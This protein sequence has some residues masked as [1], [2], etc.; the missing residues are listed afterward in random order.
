MADTTNRMITES[1]YAT[2]I[3]EAGWIAASGDVDFTVATPPINW[4]SDNKRGFIIISPD[5]LAK[6]ERMFYH[7]VIGS[8]IYV[9]GINRTDAKA[10]LVSE[11]VQINDSSDLFNYF[12]DISSNTFYIIKTGGLNITVLGWPTMLVGTETKTAADTNITLSDD[13][14]NYIYYIPSTNLVASTTTFSAIAWLSGICVAD[15]VTSGWLVSSVEYRNYKLWGMSP[16]ETGPTGPTG[17]SITWPVGAKGATGADST[18]T[19]PTG[20]DWIDWATW[21]TGAT[22]AVSNPW[23]QDYSDIIKPVSWAT[24]AYDDGASTITI[25]NPS[26]LQSDKLIFRTTGMEYQDSLGNIISF[27]TYS[28]VYSNIGTRSM[29]YSG[30]VVDGTTGWQTISSGRGIYQNTINNFYNTNVFRGDVIFKRSPSFPYYDTVPS[31]T[32]C[33]FDANNWGKQKITIA[34][35]GTYTL[36]FSNLKYWANYE[37]AIVCTH[38]TGTVTIDEW[39]IT[40][41][42]SITSYYTVW[43]TSGVTYPKTLTNGVH[44]FVWDVFTTAIHIVYSGKSVAF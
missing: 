12:S 34:T 43:G 27:A 20:A 7:N 3:T 30:I 28:G 23:E 9:K 6:R 44:L 26:S 19:G 4:I 32:V 5:T 29:T 33:T 38:S 14:T 35:A 24:V 1:F 11:V 40:N 42:G 31:G 8:R 15:I 37:L 39:T 16:W 17:A 10:H 18:V 22:G 25:T 41:S 2:T 13:T 36:N 21:P